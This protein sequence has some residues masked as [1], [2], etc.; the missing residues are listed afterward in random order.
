MYN[1]D[2]KLDEQDIEEM[3][4]ETNINYIQDSQDKITILEK[5]LDKLI[6]NVFDCR[7][8]KVNLHNQVVLFDQND[9][10]INKFNKKQLKNYLLKESGL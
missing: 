6:D 2:D 3:F 8:S 1:Y 4:E 5:A 10:V 7:I 9:C